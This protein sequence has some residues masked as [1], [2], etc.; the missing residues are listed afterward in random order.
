MPTFQPVDYDPFAKTPGATSARPTL[1][2]QPQPS[3]APRAQQRPQVT[4][5]P[6]EGNPFQPAVARPQID[7]GTGFFAAAKRGFKRSLPETESLLY[8][9]LAAGAKAVGADGVSDWALKH[10]RDV[11]DNE[12]TPLANQHGFLDTVQGNGSWGEYLGDT[13][14]NFAGQGLQSAALATAGALAGGAVGGAATPEVLGAGAIPGAVL[15]AVGGV[16]LRAGGKKLVTEAAEKLVK[17]QIE[18]GVG[19]EAAELA[20]QQ[21]VRKQ[22]QRAGGATLGAAGL[23]VAQE[24][25]TSYTG[26]ADDA[27]AA[28]Q[29]LTKGDAL[30]AIAAGV[31]AG[32]LDTVA[33]DLMTVRALHGASGSPRITRRIAAGAA[34]G[35]LTEGSTEAAQAAL[36]RAGSGQSLTDSDAIKDYIENAAAGAVGGV[37]FGGSGGIRR[38]MDKAHAKEGTVA[39]RPVVEQA[40]DGTMRALPAPD[41]TPGYGTHIVTPQGTVITPEDQSRFGNAFEQDRLNQQAADIEA[42]R[43]RADI[44]L[45]PDVNAAR[46]S[47]PAAVPNAPLVAGRPVITLAGEAQGVLGAVARRAQQVLPDSASAIPASHQP[48]GEGGEMSAVA[49]TITGSEPQKAAGDVDVQRRALLPQSLPW[50][51]SDTGEYSQPTDADLKAVMHEYLSRA[52]SS[53]LGASTPMLINQMKSFDSSL[54]S[55]RLDRVMKEAKA[56]RKKASA[57]MA[58]STGTT[59]TSGQGSV[60]PMAEADLAAAV[61]PR[62]AASA[63]LSHQAAAAPATPEASAFATPESQALATGGA[64]SGTP[65]AAGLESPSSEHTPVAVAAS[66]AATSPTNDL[67]R[68]S[69]AQLEAGNF[70][71][72]RVRINGMD[73]SIEHPAGVKRNPDHEQA[74]QHAYG[75]IRRT[76][77][78]DGEK[79]DAF[80]GPHATDESRP[81]FVVDQHNKDGSF[82]EHKVM[83]GFQNEQEARDAYL[84]NYPKD[85]NGLGGIQQMSHDEFKQWVQNPKKTAAPAVQPFK[86]QYKP[87]GRKDSK[88]RPILSPVVD[89]SHDGLLQWLGAGGGV[90]FDAVRAQGGA[91]HALL[92]D[93]AVMRPFGRVGWPALRREGGMSLDTLVEKMQ[94]DG[95]LPPSE[96]GRPSQAEVN[97]ALDLVMDA[98]N[99]HSVT[100]PVEGQDLRHARMEA[101]RQA[102]GEAEDRLA[103]ELGF[104]NAAA[105]D[106]AV[107]AS[108]DRARSRGEFSMEDAEGAR[109]IGELLAHPAVRS[110]PENE[111]GRILPLPER[112]QAKALWGIIKRDEGNGTD[113]RANHQRDDGRDEARG[114]ESGKVLGSGDPELRQGPDGSG[115]DEGGVREDRPDL[116]G[117]TGPGDQGRVSQAPAASGQLFGEPTAADKVDA[118]RREK[119]AQRDGRDAAG[120]TDM[121][122]GDGELFAGNRPEQVGIETGTLPEEDAAS[123]G[124][125][126]ALPDQSAGDSVAESPGSAA[127]RGTGSAVRNQL[128]LFVHTGKQEGRAAERPAVDV[129]K[130]KQAASLVRTGEFRTGIARVETL[131]DAAHILAP[132]RKSAQEQFLA[133]A[134]DKDGKPLAVLKH[135]VGGID[136]SQVFPGTVFGAIAAVDGADSVVFAHNHPSGND[137][138]SGADIGLDQNLLAAFRDS[139]INVRGSIILQPGRKTYTIYGANGGPVSGGHSK[140]DIKPARRT[141]AVPQVERALTKVMPVEGRKDLKSPDAALQYTKDLRKEYRSGVILLNTRHEVIGVIP[142]DPARTERLRTGDK[143]TSHATIAKQVSGANAAASILYGDKRYKTGILNMGAALNLSDARV[144]DSILFD[145]DTPESV[146][147]QGGNS[148]SRTLYSRR[149]WGDFPDAVLGNSNGAAQAHPDYAAAK[150]GDDAAALKLARD[151]VAPEYVKAIRDALPAGAKPTIV[152]VM[153]REAS[154]NNRIP[155]MV[156]RVLAA[157]LGFPLADNIVQS[158]KVSRG[159]SDGFHR[160]ANAPTFDGRVVKGREYLILDDTLAQGGTLA[161]LKTHIEDN[162]G[163]VVLASALTGKQYSAKMAISPERLAKLRDKFGS[164][165]NWWR[166]QFGHGFEGFTESEGRFLTELK[167]SPT[168]EQIRDRVAAARVQSLLSMG[169]RDDQVGQDQRPVARLSYAQAQDLKYLLTRNWGDNA[170]TIRIVESAE[171]LQRAAGLPRSVLNDPDF[172]RAEG[173]YRGQPAVYLNVDAIRTPE[174]FAQVLAHEAIGHYGVERVIGKKEWKSITDAITQHERDGTGIADIRKAIEQVKKTQPDIDPKADPENFAKEV[175]A[176]MAENG[177]N[178]GLLRRVV[179]AVR[180]YLRQI[181]PDMKWGDADIVRL[182]ADA[183]GFLRQ[184]TPAY[185][186]RAALQQRMAFSQAAE[187]NSPQFKKWFGESKVVKQDGAPRVVYHGTA[188]EFWAF[189]KSKL[190][191]NTGHM[192]A[193]FGFYFAEQKEKA[194]HYAEKNSDGVPADERVIDAYLS[195]KNPATMSLKEFQAID[196]FDEAKALRRKLEQQGHDGIHVPE[197]RQWV[198]FEPEQVKSA[199]ENVGTYDSKNPDIRYSK[200]ENEDTP[201]ARALAEV[202]KAMDP[203]KGATRLEKAKS[204]LSDLTPAKVKDAARQHWLGYLTLSHLVELAGDRIPGIQVYGKLQ[205]EMAGMRAQLEGEGDDRARKWQVWAGKNPKEFEKQRDLMHDATMRGVDPAEDYQPLTFK[206]GGQTREVNKANINEALKALEEQARGLA[207]E[208]KQD[209]YNEMNALKAMLADE[210]KRKGAYPDLRARWDALSPAAKEHYTAVRD[211]YR[212]RS[213]MTEQLLVDR[214]NNTD[215]TDT[216]KR[217]LVNMIRQQFEQNRLSGV[218]FPLQR[219]GAYFIA[220]KKGDLT[221]FTR[222]ETES[223]AARGEQSLKKDG[224]E[225][226]ASGLRSEQKAS[227]APPESFVADVI[228]I[229]Q[230]AHISQETQDNVYQA[231]LETLPELSMRKHQIHRKNIP[232]FDPDALRAFAHNMRHS[233]TQLARMKYSPMLTDQMGVMEKHVDELRKDPSRSLNDNAAADAILGEL[234]Q[235]HEW[236]MNPTDSKL[237]GKLT[238]LGFIYYLGLSPAS[239]LTNLTQTPIITFPYLAARYGAGNAARAL[240]QASKFAGRSAMAITKD[241]VNDWT[242]KDPGY[243]HRDRVQLA[244]GDEAKAMQDLEKAGVLDRTQS[245]SLAG[246]AEH[247]MKDY[248]PAKAKALSIVGYGFHITEVMNREATGLATYRLARAAG[249]NH[250]AAVAAAIE[251]I[252]QTHYNYSNANRARFM[253]SGMAKTVLLFRQYALNTSWHWGRML[254]NATKS[255]DPETR[256]IA[257][258]NIAGLVGMTGLFSG[259]MGMPVA[260]MLTTAL[261]A[262]AASFGDDDEPWDAE[263][264]FGHFLDEVFGKGA[265]DVIQHGAVNKLT[266]IDLAGR[267]GMADMWY[268]DSNKDLTG[269]PFYDYLLEQAAGP[270]FDM[271]GNFMEGKQLIDE[272]HLGRGVEKMVPNA[273]K[274][275]MRAYRYSTEGVTNINGDPIV[276]DLST[277]EKASAALGFTPARV[278]AQ[279]EEN[280]ALKNYEA[281]VQKRRQ[282]LMDAYALA[283]RIGDSDGRSDVLDQVRAFNQ[284]WPQIAITPKTLNLSLRAHERA[285]RQTMHGIKLSQKLGGQIRTRV[286]ADDEDDED[287]EG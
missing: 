108:S 228:K 4:F 181:M 201:E 23:N 81:V 226:T 8:G 115:K 192:T 3:S 259:A 129:G 72:G 118:A 6:V 42:A 130:L 212:A 258:R 219:Y 85:W 88:G 116:F 112:D 140:S 90:N 176:V 79:V 135:T 21:Y 138:P 169:S 73:L 99:G 30:R 191:S 32:L 107:R 208:S 89:L 260:G 1:T 214:I 33:E 50:I 218:Y 150:A 103:R 161:E 180:K 53:G 209:I 11:T 35:A 20:G 36:E 117:G 255:S 195:I 170:P 198:A 285:S 13:I 194:E 222:Y 213:D 92:K 216:Q 211:M 204:F 149:G 156:G 251:A 102:E 38:N 185:E 199:S 224:W 95:W 200:A 186:R 114:P 278:A 126:R 182:L 274:Y 210:P 237:A 266:G 48:G 271:L 242:D 244:N 70:K 193:P 84:S 227:K 78:A 221:S 105:M 144:L 83:L 175:I 45:T 273:L 183:H 63:P 34:Q 69:E 165:E 9:G 243:R 58:S 286:G 121:A 253:Q 205:Q 74:L 131:D 225:I 188:S 282:S 245:M 284:K 250:A 215:A 231:F 106:E 203:F 173:L 91:D 25:G 145:G 141:S 57:A 49:A 127:G 7:G 207:G 18:K 276:D 136:S 232:G 41:G 280:S 104:E 160:L 139:G 122:A 152:P 217:R 67:P 134:L 287:D 109:S 24:V 257:R 196:N 241:S 40:P 275:A 59:Q 247:G 37:A 174:R 248:S 52:D 240:L 120:R 10:Y 146:A 93:N 164:I 16:A 125:T 26:R 236:L 172:Y 223:D 100:H 272:G 39:G 87:S 31:P 235:R 233:A 148:A 96:D 143:N 60:S 283:S 159:G 155:L 190:A 111:L 132:L 44:G 220:A 261:N 55:K 119:D 147:A 254:W 128:D 262:V 166:E 267:V 197:I 5:T 252:N 187:P 153:A 124:R 27:E 238:G 98:I 239:A 179:A 202:A 171:E 94:E 76:E 51:N 47:H 64:Q 113:R 15:G 29:Q 123:Y 162:G 2:Q 54:D 43:A 263:T 101:D 277:A 46:T 206:Y 133:L 80:L 71:V 256:K 270:A 269:R 12:V 22:L 61:A 65:A 97:H 168:A 66:Q 62:D 189:D 75:Y 264:E 137:A 82:D 229:M 230:E 68:P 249:D 151:M 279:Y 19:R 246:I 77:G 154:G 142:F 184:G 234:S 110:A 167:G 86:R 281:Y 163:K 265:S 14:G 56:E 177:A 268:R 157:K 28:G 17:D 158:K 178:N